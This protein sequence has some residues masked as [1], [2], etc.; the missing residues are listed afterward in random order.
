MKLRAWNPAIIRERLLT[1]EVETAEKSCSSDPCRSGWASVLYSRRNILP[2]GSSRQGRPSHSQ[3]G[4]ARQWGGGGGGLCRGRR[5]GHSLHCLEPRTRSLFHEM[6]FSHVFPRESVR[7]FFPSSFFHSPLC[8]W[9][10]GPVA[11]ALTAGE[12]PESG[13][14]GRP[15]L[16][17]PASLGLPSSAR[18]TANC[19]SHDPLQSCR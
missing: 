11:A 16:E 5:S 13:L 2:G 19:Q 12:K 3:L 17:L 4:L 18:D 6:L 15:T 9:P 1:W 7:G 14:V 10:R 8:V